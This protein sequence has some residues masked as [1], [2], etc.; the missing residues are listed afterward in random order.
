MDPEEQEAKSKAHS[1]ECFL[2]LA[3]ST[4]NYAIFD[5][6]FQFFCVCKAEEVLEQGEIAAFSMEQHD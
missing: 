1:N 5:R 4:G 3:L 6:A 2:V